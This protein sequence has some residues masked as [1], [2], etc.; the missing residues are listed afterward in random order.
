MYSEA[1]IAKI[2]QKIEYCVNLNDHCNASLLRV[3]LMPPIMRRMQNAYRTILQEIAD[4]QELQGYLD[5]EDIKMRDMI[6][7]KVS[8]I[9]KSMKV[10]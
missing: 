10:V 9:L 8:K 3:S 6:D 5:E 7:K 4:T 2:I 1:E